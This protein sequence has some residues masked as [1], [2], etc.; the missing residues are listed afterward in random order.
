M[1]DETSLQGPA[2]PRAFARTTALMREALHSWDLV[3][4]L[5]AKLGKC[6]QEGI[7]NGDPNYP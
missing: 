1:V 4:S 6:E 2:G 3:G 7:L 5:H